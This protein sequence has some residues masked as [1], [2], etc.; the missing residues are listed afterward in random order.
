MI[1]SVRAGCSRFKARKA[2]HGRRSLSWGG[3]TRQGPRAERPSQRCKSSCGIFGLQFSPELWISVHHHLRN[4]DYVLRAM[5]A[6]IASLGLT[7]IRGAT[8]S[9]FP[10]HTPF[11]QHIQSGVVPGVARSYKW[12]RKQLSQAR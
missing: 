3:E 2:I 4:G 1:S 7:K 5:M 8:T 9:L 11:V 12:R 6:E 10:I